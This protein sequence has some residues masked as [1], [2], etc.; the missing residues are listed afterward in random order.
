MAEDR[1][2]DFA[3]GAVAELLRVLKEEEAADVH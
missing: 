3:R 2:A 1:V